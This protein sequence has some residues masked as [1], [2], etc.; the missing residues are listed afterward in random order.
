MSQPIFELRVCVRCEVKW[1]ED[2]PAIEVE[3][4]GKPVLPAGCWRR[5]LIKLE[6]KPHDKSVT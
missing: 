3:V 5:E 6:P 4:G 1:I 2:C